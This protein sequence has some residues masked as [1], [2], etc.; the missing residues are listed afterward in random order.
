[1]LRKCDILPL[2]N[3][4]TNNV[5]EEFYIPLLSNCKEYKRVSAYFDSHILEL[6]SSGIE[7][8]VLQNGHVF[9]IFSSESFFMISLLLIIFCGSKLFSSFSPS[10]DSIKFSFVSV[11]S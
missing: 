1:M 11:S 8:I 7:N 6:Y 4:K 2:Y 5:L 10:E 3:T 9:F